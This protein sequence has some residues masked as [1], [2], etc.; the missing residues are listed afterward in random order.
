MART[1]SRFRKGKTPGAPSAPVRRDLDSLIQGVSQQPPHLRLVGQCQEQINGWSSPVEGLSKRNC[2]RLIGK[3]AD[4]VLDDFYMDILNVMQGEYYFGLVRPGTGDTTILELKN[5]TV[6]STG[7]GSGGEE[8]IGM[9]P[10][11]PTNIDIHGTG[12]TISSGGQVVCDNTSYLHNAAGDFYKKYVLINTGPIGLLLNREK[13]TAL[14]DD[15]IAEQTGKGIVFIQAV[16]YNVTY[17]VT[18]NDDQVATFTT[19]KADD[20]PNAI[21]TSTVAESLRQQINNEAGYTATRVQYVIY[22]VKDDGTDFKL[23]IDDGRSGE[24]AN[25]FNNKVQDISKLPIIAPDDYR[26]EVE[27][28]PTIT[29]DNR[30]LKFTTN[31][32]TSPYDVFGDGGWSETTAP[33]IKYILDEDT[34]PL[35]IYRATQDVFFIGPADGA[36]RSQTVSGTTYDY[37]FPEWGTRSAGNNKTNPKPEFVGEAI[38]DHII[39]RSR[40]VVA[41]GESVTLSETNDI[42]N[43]FLDTSLAVIATDSFGLRG[44][45]EKSSPMEWM[46]PVEDSILAFSSTSQFQIRAADADVLTPATGEIFR[47]SNLEMNS[48]VR[49]KLSGTQVLFPTNYFGYSHF[50]EF[51]FGNNSRTSRLGLNLGSSLDITNYVPKYIQGLVKNWDVGEAVDA[52]V[53]IS[54]TNLKEL[55][56]YKYYWTNSEQGQQK[57]QRSWSKWQFNQDVRWVKFVDNSLYMLVSDATGTYFGVQLNDEIEL[58]TAPQIYLDRLIQLPAP[59]FSAPTGTVTATYDAATD[60]TTFTLPY[61]PATEALCVVRFTNSNNQ[62]LL[63]GSSATNTIVATTK[64]DFTSYNLAFGERYKFEYEFNTGYTPD[65]NETNSRIIGQLAGRTQ[66]LRWTVNHVDTGEYKLR[67]RRLNRNDDTVKSFRARKLRESNSQ[68]TYSDDWL[69]NGSIDVPVCSKNDQCQVSVESDSWLPIT[70]TS[71]SWQGLYSD[72]QKAI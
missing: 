69:E 24:L 36:A 11:T 59:D 7:V 30:Y 15:V 72:R 67:V 33:G 10:L 35:V 47:L 52:A 19:P 46:I 22:V 8:E 56:V 68:L 3:F 21:S 18:I 20:D 1:K 17:T 57:I 51:Q 23:I 26:V 55:F 14:K 37:T 42:F 16:A 39:F 45:S 43:F 6:V 2:M 13:I 66:I 53:A 28:D 50:R 63:L 70:V 41:A 71:A 12:M 62:G 29:I 60:I 61:T 27:S 34:M 40:Y 9:K 65:K 49:P 48:N 58:R 54:P 32:T 64:G 38:R 5:D 25:A 4:F 31:S 44:T